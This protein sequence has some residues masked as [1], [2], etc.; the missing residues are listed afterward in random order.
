MEENK[1][2][3][4]VQQKKKDLFFKRTNGY[5]NL[6]PG[7]LEAIHTY[8][9]GYKTFLDEGKIERAC[10]DYAIRLAEAAGFR[11]L[12]RGQK[13]KPGDKVYRNN[14]GKALMLAVIGTRPLDQGTVI[15]AAHI[16]APR[17]DIK[18]NPLYEEKELAYLREIGYNNHEV[19][20]IL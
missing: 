17:L 7:E 1:E 12:L 3:S 6:A 11:P 10:V 4:Q 18:Q 19:S 9:E 8:C 2:Q 14:R 16:D 20:V 5:D 13:L 15:G